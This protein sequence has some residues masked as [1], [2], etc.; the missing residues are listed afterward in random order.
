M[1]KMYVTDKSCCGV[2][3]RFSDDEV[4]VVKHS[5]K[6]VEFEIVFYVCPEVGP[7]AMVG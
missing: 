6:G 3:H 7:T 5:Y 1:K 4:D 2:A